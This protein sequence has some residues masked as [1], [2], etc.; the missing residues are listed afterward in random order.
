[1]LYFVEFVISK[2][3]LDLFVVKIGLRNVVSCTAGQ[4]VENIIIVV[5]VWL[6]VTTHS[7]PVPVGMSVVELL[8]Q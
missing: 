4:S 6:V 1:M 8:S 5:M 3:I 7:P 2:R